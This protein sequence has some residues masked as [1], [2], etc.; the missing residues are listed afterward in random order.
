M[1]RRRHI[2]SG[3]PRHMYQ[4]RFLKGTATRD[5]DKLKVLALCSHVVAVAHAVMAA[6]RIACAWQGR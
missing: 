5:H 1:R 2:V 4:C 3:L 6:D